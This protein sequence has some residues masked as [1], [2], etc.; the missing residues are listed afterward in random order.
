MLNKI[1]KLK[2]ISGEVPIPKA[3]ASFD[4]WYHD[5]LCVNDL[6]SEQVILEGIR[7]S[8]RG[9]A[10]DITRYLRPSAKVDDVVNKLDVI[11]GSV[12]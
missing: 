5:D 10:A 8:P 6:Y 11:Y 1:P 7:Q 2:V 4:Q 9:P 12:C 3:E